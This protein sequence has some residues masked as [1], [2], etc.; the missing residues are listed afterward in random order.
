[1]SARAPLQL[2]LVEWERSVDIKPMHGSGAW[3]S[4]QKDEPPKTTDIPPSYYQ[5]P[6]LPKSCFSPKI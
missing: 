1:M 3:W 5:L 4:G 2:V 6:Q